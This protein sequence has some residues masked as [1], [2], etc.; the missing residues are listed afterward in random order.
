M[1]MEPN[2][3]RGTLTR[4][5]AAVMEVRNPLA[6]QRLHVGLRVGTVRKSRAQQAGPGDLSVKLQH[7]VKNWAWLRMLVT[8]ALV[9]TYQKE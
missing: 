8:T 3:D 9:R 5:Q 7:R 1:E 6:E 2:R 4:S